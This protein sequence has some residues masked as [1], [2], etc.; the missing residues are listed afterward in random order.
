MLSTVLFSTVLTVSTV[1]VAANQVLEAHKNEGRGHRHPRAMTAT[2]PHTLH[3][4][5]S[6]AARFLGLTM[7]AT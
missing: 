4:T 3:F 2:L 1:P 5:P 7:K 6:L